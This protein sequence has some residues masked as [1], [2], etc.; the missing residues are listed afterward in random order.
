MIKPKSKHIP[1]P[2]QCFTHE[3]VK[4]INKEIVNQ[5][6]V[7]ESETDRAQNAIKT[8]DFYH[9]P[10]MPLM[11]LLHPWLVQCQQINNA[12]FGYDIYWDFHLD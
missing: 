7:K 10:C 6:I 3:Q 12:V 2:I 9:V 1:D 11:E 5:N 8:G 4:K